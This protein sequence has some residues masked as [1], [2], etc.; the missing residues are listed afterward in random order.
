MNGLINNLHSPSVA[1]DE[2]NKTSTNAGSQRPQSPFVGQQAQPSSRINSSKIT[3]DDA[4]QEQNPLK[5]EKV[6]F[7]ELKISF[8]FLVNHLVEKQ[9]QPINNLSGL[10]NIQTT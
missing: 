4:K 7:F 10:C 2:S 3:R 6:F 9:V 8:L 1:P 5:F